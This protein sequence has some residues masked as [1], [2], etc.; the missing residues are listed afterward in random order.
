MKSKWIV[1]MFC[2]IVFSSCGCGPT[3]LYNWRPKPWTHPYIANAYTGLDTLININGYYVTQNSDNNGKLY[4]TMFYDN[5]LCV[6]TNTRIYLADLEKDTTTLNKVY[7]N[8]EISEYMRDY[9]SWGTYDVYNDTI[10]TYT[11]EN[12]FGCDGTRKNVISSTYLI[13]KDKQ[14]KQ[15]YISSSNK[16]YG[17]TR[18][19]DTPC[20]FYPIENKRSSDECPYLDKKWFYR[21]DKVK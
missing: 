11:I 18:I 8:Q 9:T 15:I 13:S 14:L 6:S 12:L 3:F 1:F 7:S 16:E 19:L 20:I 4:S 17:Y 2:L 5:G 21:K 10:K